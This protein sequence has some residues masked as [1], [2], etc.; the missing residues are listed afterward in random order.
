MNLCPGA[1]S[2]RAAS[3]LYL[4]G[5]VALLGLYSRGLRCANWAFLTNCELLE[6]RL[7]PLAGMQQPRFACLMCCSE[8]GCSGA[9]NCVFSSICAV[10]HQNSGQTV[11]AKWK[12]IFAVLQLLTYNLIQT[13]ARFVHQLCRR[14]EG[15]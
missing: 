8:T 7:S 13:S 5:T 11:H 3:L 6:L 2:M 15:S 10:V 9:E 12:H 1:R 4:L 14:L